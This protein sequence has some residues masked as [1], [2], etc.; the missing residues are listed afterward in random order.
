MAAIDDS[1]FEMHA[2]DDSDFDFM[3]DGEE[4]VAPP[5]KKVGKPAPKASKGKNKKSN[6]ILSS[7]SESASNAASAAGKEDSET[8]KGKGKTI[9]ERYQKM[10]QLEHV[11]KRPDTYI[12]SV[13]PLQQEMFVYE[14]DKDAIVNKEITFT[15][16]L[17]KIFDE[18]KFHQAQDFHCNDNPWPHRL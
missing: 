14:A 5:S 15:P 10:S 6:P 8:T 11:L 1:D 3:S 4:N 13:E 16:G 7:R 17:Y 9:E 12:G 18:S 2:D